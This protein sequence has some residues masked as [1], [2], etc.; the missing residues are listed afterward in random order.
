MKIG[1]WTS[2]EKLDAMKA[3]GWVERSREERLDED[4]IL[5]TLYHED[6]KVVTHRSLP[7]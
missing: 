2:E 3:K 4:R 5:V 7:L 6:D 1:N